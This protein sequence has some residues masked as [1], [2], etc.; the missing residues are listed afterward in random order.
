LW[1]QWRQLGVTAFAVTSF[2]GWYGL[3]LLHLFFRRSVLVWMTLTALSFGL[4]FGSFFHP[5]R[6]VNGGSS[7]IALGEGLVRVVHFDI[8]GE[9]ISDEQWQRDIQERRKDNPIP[10]ERLL[11]PTKPWEIRFLSD[12]WL[13]RILQ[14][15]P[16]HRTPTRLQPYK[17]WHLLFPFFPVP[18]IL[19]MGSIRAYRR[20]QMSSRPAVQ[21]A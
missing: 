4:L 8:E 21:S 16:D 6:L 5:I 3:H 14:F 13:A 20:G 9:P 2:S 17:G 11:I 19:L 12:I 18:I 15:G 10:G 1:R 7:G